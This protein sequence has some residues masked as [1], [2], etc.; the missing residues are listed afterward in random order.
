MGT[1]PHPVIP[2]TLKEAQEY[3]RSMKVHRRQCVLL[4]ALVEKAFTAGSPV[5]SDPEAG[6]QWDDALT[7]I[8]EHLSDWCK[9]DI[10]HSFLKSDLIRLGIDQ[11]F[12]ELRWCGM[13]PE[14]LNLTEKRRQDEDLL[15]DTLRTIVSNIEL[16][17]RTLN[18]PLDRIQF[19]VGKL[20]TAL[21]SGINT[22]SVRSKL[23]SALMFLYKNASVGLPTPDL[24]AQIVDI[25][26]MPYASDALCR[27]HHA[28]WLSQER[29]EVKVLRLVRYN[30]TS[31]DRFRREVSEF[32]SVQHQNI[33]RVYGIVLNE[34][35][36]CC[37]VTP[38]MNKANALAYLG[39]HGDIQ[40]LPW[41]KDI[42]IA[43]QYL[44]AL[45]PPII[46]GCLRAENILI[47]DD[48]QRACIADFGL[49][50]L[51]GQMPD[52]VQNLLRW[53]APELIRA[54]KRR[55]QVGDMISICNC[56][57]DIYSFGIVMFVVYWC[58]P[59]LPYRRQR[60]LRA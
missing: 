36:G 18:Q 51:S 41:L 35:L 50:P 46:G 39:N 23:D 26:S 45:T 17:K 31:A 6:Q 11:L 21:K 55:E 49:F 13:R 44:H 2:D 20:Q 14:D 12:G 40:V 58:D 3:A 16:L 29:V 19:F 48:G 28:N 52:N 38:S 4:C 7:I 60:D 25:D 54:A 59:L 32:Y 57:T 27:A 15:Q 1:S 56:K 53:C 37:V 24:T 47:K 8:H 34:F 9:L 42:A 5:Q 30:P 10:V 33:V 43:L 22:D